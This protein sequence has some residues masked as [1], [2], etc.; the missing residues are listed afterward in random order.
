MKRTILAA[1]AAVLASVAA[2]HAQETQ[3]YSY[4]VH[5]RLTS[6]A[7]TVGGTTRTTAYVLDDAD[8]RTT[9]TTTVAA[10]LAEPSEAAP[11]P[12]VSSPASTEPV[13]APSAASQ[14]PRVS[15]TADAPEAAR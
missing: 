6:V 11:V 14:A 7:R 15:E 2:A 12:A 8:N 13:P 10:G 1:G 4:D 9:R 5:G 3:T